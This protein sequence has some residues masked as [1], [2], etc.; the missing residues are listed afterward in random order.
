MYMREIIRKLGEYI[1]HHND[2][3]AEALYYVLCGIIYK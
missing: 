3:Y 2:K 1:N